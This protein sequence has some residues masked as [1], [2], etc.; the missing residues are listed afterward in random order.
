MSQGYV[1][2]AG[3]RIDQHDAYAAELAGADAPFRSSPPPATGPLPAAV[4]ARRGDQVRATRATRAASVP[5]GSARRPRFRRAG[6]RPGTPD[7][8]ADIASRRPSSD[9]PGVA[10]T[11]TPPCAAAVATPTTTLPWSDCQSREPSPVSRGRRVR[12]GQRSR[13]PRAPPRCRR[14]GAHRAGA[15]RSRDHRRPGAGLTLRS[16]GRA[17]EQVLGRWTH[18]RDDAR[19][20]AEGVLESL[21]FRRRALLFREHGARSLEA[22]QRRVHVT[23]DDEV[24]AP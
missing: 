22:E 16:P 21:L 13:P 2:V 4:Q 6:R 1:R 12:C 15:G 3:C 18:S 19:E 8:P 11:G 20:V 7:R 10:M 23:R 24:C 14:S 9:R 17:R 5:A